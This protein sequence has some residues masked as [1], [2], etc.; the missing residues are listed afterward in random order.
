MPALPPSFSSPSSYSAL[1]PAFLSVTPRQKITDAASVVAML[2]GMARGGGGGGGVEGRGSA[3]GG[4]GNCFEGLVEAE[5]AAMAFREGGREGG[6][7]VSKVVWVRG[8]IMP[9]SDD[10][11][12]ALLPLLLLPPSLP[13]SPPPPPCRDQRKESVSTRPWMP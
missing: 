3:R 12:S 8:D 2:G 13:P 10:W 4:I 5:F 11:R 7:G 1:L 9:S 6:R